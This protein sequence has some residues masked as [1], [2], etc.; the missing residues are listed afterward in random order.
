MPASFMDRLRTGKTDS[1]LPAAGLIITRIL[2]IFFSI[3]IF[4]LTL[5]CYCVNFALSTLTTMFLQGERN[6]MGKVYSVLSANYMA[7]W[8]GDSWH[9]HE[10]PE[11]VVRFSVV[12]TFKWLHNGN[13]S[14]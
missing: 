14:K 1:P 5:F 9:I 7:Y 13:A 12:G 2:P 6:P 4:I 11:M 8:P 3:V 10:S